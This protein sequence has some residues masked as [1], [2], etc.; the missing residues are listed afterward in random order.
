MAK[1]GFSRKA[2]IQTSETVFVVIIIMIILIIGIVFYSRAQEGSFREQQ[3]EQRILRLISLA[4]SISSWPELEC[5]NLESREYDC[6]DRL[7][8]DIAEEFISSNRQNSSFAFN[9]YNDL[10]RRSS[11]TVH[12][13]Y[14]YNSTLQDWVIYNNTAGRGNSESVFVPV[15]IYDPVEQVFTFAVMELRAYE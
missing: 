7:K 5:S 12:E 3:R 11:I 9:Y 13:V 1:T 2:Q 4:H 8:L 6:I 14:S 15:N 10:L